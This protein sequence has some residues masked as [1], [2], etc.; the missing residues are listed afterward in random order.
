MF[1][2]Q[3]A[4]TAKE[5]NELMIVKDNLERMIGYAESDYRK[6]KKLFKRGEISKDELIEC[7]NRLIKLKSELDEV[8]FKLK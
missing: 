1:S 7:E 3:E 5:Y 4:T 2:E 6:A 8:N